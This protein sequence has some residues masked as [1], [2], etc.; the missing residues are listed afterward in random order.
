ML[1]LVLGLLV[2]G[3]EGRLGHKMEKGVR[4]VSLGDALGASR[5]KV[6]EESV[7]ERGDVSSRPFFDSSSSPGSSPSSGKKKRQEKTMPQPELTN[8]R[9]LPM[10]A[11]I[12]NERFFFFFFF[13]HFSFFIFHFF[14]FFFIFFSF[15]FFFLF[16][17]YFF[18]LSPFP[19]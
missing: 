10:E 9:V 18:F 17:L 8:S 6:G 7:E 2:V 13:F 15:F 12:M 14:S 16:S 19:P 5:E 11:Y 1:G 3:L 4:S